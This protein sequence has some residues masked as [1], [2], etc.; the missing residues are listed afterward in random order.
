MTACYYVQ[1]TDEVMLEL[2]S[3]GWPEGLRPV[4]RRPARP[5]GYPGTAW[6]LF[7]DDN[8][9]PEADGRAFEILFSRVSMPQAR[10]SPVAS[11]FD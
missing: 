9:P 5:G 6:W 4:F 8:A 3:D 11:F 2:K 1:A 7:E 10:I